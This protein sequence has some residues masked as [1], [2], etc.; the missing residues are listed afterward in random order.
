MV[1]PQEMLIKVK[2]T[3]INDE[4]SQH[5]TIGLI[6]QTSVQS[7]V[8]DLKKKKSISKGK[9]QVMNSQLESIDSIQLKKIIKREISIQASG[10]KI[11]NEDVA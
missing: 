11:A 6:P 2:L 8:K 5:L 3:D 7:N 4:E 9:A 10:K 1:E